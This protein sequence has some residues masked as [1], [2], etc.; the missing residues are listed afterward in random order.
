MPSPSTTETAHTR[1]LSAVID[2]SELITISAARTPDSIAEANSAIAVIADRVAPQILLQAISSLSSHLGLHTEYRSRRGHVK[3]L[4]IA[5]TPANVGRHIGEVLH[6][7]RESV[8]LE[9][10]CSRKPN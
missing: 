10:R 7:T 9:I 4:I 2:L 8:D 6:R 1:F 3:H 5:S